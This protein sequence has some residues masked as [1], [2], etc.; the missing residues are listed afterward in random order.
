[1]FSVLAATAA[2]VLLYRLAEKLFDQQVALVST[3]VFLLNSVFLDQ[4]R[5]VRMYSLGLA[6]SLAA[7]LALLNA[8][9]KCSDRS[10]NSWMFLRILS[11]LTTPLSALLVPAETLIA[12]S[13]L[14]GKRRRMLLLQAAVCGLAFLPQV[15]SLLQQRQ[16]FFSGFTSKYPAPNLGQALFQAFLNFSLGD[17]PP[18]YGPPSL[19]PLGYPPFR[20]A[21]VFGLVLLFGVHLVSAGPRSLRFSQKQS[22]ISALV[23]IPWTLLFIISHTAGNLWVPRYFIF[24]QPYFAILLGLAFVKALMRFPRVVPLAGA[25]YL[26]AAFLTVG[27]YFERSSTLLGWREVAL[28]I[29]RYERPGDRIVFLHSGA[30]R[31][32]LAL[33][34]YYHGA[35]PILLWDAPSVRGSDLV[36]RKAFVSRCLGQ[37]RQ[38]GGR[39]WLIQARAQL[40]PILIDR[41]ISSVSLFLKTMDGSVFLYVPHDHKAGQKPVGRN[42]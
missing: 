18:P 11:I 25:A 10:L 1:M 8:V 23:L 27:E 30:R 42:P 40:D 13:T 22:W 38:D 35:S 32:S 4:A 24:I 37:I 26:I 3:Y 2:L 39:A 31:T 7:S 17:I 29:E 36:E 28:S 20:M 16:E 19:N 6:F 15:L 33:R 12:W 14:A 9:L 5:Q 34:H 41:S 21:L